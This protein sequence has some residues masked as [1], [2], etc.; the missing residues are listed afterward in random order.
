MSDRIIVATFDN[1]DA[2]YDAA[3]AIKDLT[4]IG[5][6][7]FKLKAGVMVQKNTIGVVSTLESRDRPPLA[8]VITTAV[9]A[10]VGLIGGP[11]GAAIGAAV[12]AGAGLTGDLITMMFDDRF[13]ESVI[14]DMQPGSTSL[15][16]E[17]DEGSTRAVDDI[18]A[19][20]HGKVHRQEMNRAAA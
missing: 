20:R 6:A 11:P 17:A 19:L 8:T 5:G 18:V 9:G 16:V 14:S 2:A 3:A 10:L 4:R 13:V 15:I 7:D 1:T 12:G